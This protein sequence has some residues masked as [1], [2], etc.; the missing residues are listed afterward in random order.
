M[1]PRSL[2]LI[3]A[4]AVLTT[5]GCATKTITFRSTSPASGG[6]K[7]KVVAL[8]PGKLDEGGTLLGETPLTV[9]I[10]KLTGKVVRMEQ[11]GKQ[12][13]Y[14]I[15]TDAAGDKVEANVTMLDDPAALASASAT[16]TG[17]RPDPKATEN[18]IGRL[19]LKSYQALSSKQFGPAREL[20][21]QAATIKPE[22]AAPHVIKGLSF[23]QEGNAGEARAS[24]MKAQALDPEDKDLETLLKVTQ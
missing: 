14:W 11:P 15:I 22:L 10:E 9:E 8:S 4:F 21:D 17:E 12:S 13:V 20:A 19:L 5:A 1:M 7:A 2:P 3:L 24:F 16:A 6:G 18:R 23:Y